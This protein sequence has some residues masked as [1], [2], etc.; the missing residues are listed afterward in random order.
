MK[1]DMVTLTNFNISVAV[2]E[3]FMQAVER[4]ESYELRS[5][6]TGEAVGTRD[7]REMFDR[8]V[9]NAWRNGDPG[10]IFIDRINA[11]ESNPTPKYGR[12]EATNPCGE[13]PLF[14]YESCNLGSIN[15]AMFI[16]EVD[17]QKAIDWEHL[18]AVVDVTVRFLDNVIDMNRYPI[19]QIEDWSRKMR[20][21]GLGV[22]GFADLLFQLKVSYNSDEGVRLGQEVMAFIQQRSNQASAVLS[23]E[24]GVY[25]AWEDSIHKEAGLRYRNCNRTVIAPTG[26]ISIIADCSSGIE[27]VFALAFVRQHF[28]DPKDPSKRTQLTD[29]NDYFLKVAKGKASI[30][31][32]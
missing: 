11:S 21:I 3:E 24:R 23:E 27:P 19:P 7:A 9:T 14:P 4:G 15:L 20:R 16:K 31:T 6:R 13:E 28:L 29:V 8:M 1:A 22:M 18:G 12:I 32:S 17:G 26:T 5:P 2:T 10:L 25:P 30:L